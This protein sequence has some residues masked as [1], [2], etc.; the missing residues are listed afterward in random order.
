MRICPI[1]A[2]RLFDP[3]YG[4]HYAALS[5]DHDAPYWMVHNKTH[6]GVTE[7]QSRSSHSAKFDP[8][9]RYIQ[10]YTTTVSAFA[11]TKSEV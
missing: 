11:K 7:T 3:N 1:K 5:S 2:Q 10:H 4:K 8:L 6:R 9:A